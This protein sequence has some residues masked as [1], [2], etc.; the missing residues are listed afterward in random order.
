[1]NALR[2]IETAHEIEVRLQSNE[3]LVHLPQDT[4]LSA[5]PNKI[6]EA[7]YKADKTVCL[8]A[9]GRWTEDGFL[10]EGWSHALAAPKPNSAENGIWQLC[11]ER[12]QDRWVL[13]ASQN[14]EAVP[15][16]RDEDSR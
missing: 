12:E 14:L 13:K 10:P 9:E 7:G 2:D 1:M 8:L 15:Q 3:V 16:I 5:V 4:P 6:H 11:F